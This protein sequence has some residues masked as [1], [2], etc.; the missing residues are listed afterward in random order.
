MW[1]AIECAYSD[2]DV[3]E[4]QSA[5]DIAYTF[6]ERCNYILPCI[7]HCSP[8]NIT[9]QFTAPPPTCNGDTFTF[10]CTVRDM[11][12]VTIWRVGGSS[13]CSLLHSTA[14]APRT[15]GSGSTFTAS[16]GTGFGTSATSYSSTLSGTAISALN[17]TL[18]ECFGP[19]LARVAENTVGKNTIQ[20]I[21]QYY[22]LLLM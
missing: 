3:H 6:Y 10:R 17:G 13:E 16:P 11:S 4:I 18:V 2:D 21:G 8:D 9:A 1:K 12:G 22:V 19:G 7:H 20:I 15:C 5:H 14:S